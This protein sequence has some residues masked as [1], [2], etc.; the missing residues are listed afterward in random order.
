[1]QDLFTKKIELPSKIQFPWPLM[2]RLKKNKSGT[3]YLAGKNS[4]STQGKRGKFFIN[5]LQRYQYLVT[6]QTNYIRMSVHSFD[7]VI[8]ENLVN[9]LSLYVSELVNP[10]P[11]L[12]KVIYKQACIFLHRFLF[13]APPRCS[14]FFPCPVF[15][16]QLNPT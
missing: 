3:R 2:A 7:K 9:I 5:H 13:Y 4:G 10:L 8:A 15:F 6:M 14:G 11:S 12:Q 16:I 1:M